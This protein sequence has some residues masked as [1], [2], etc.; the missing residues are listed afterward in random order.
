MNRTHE[1]RHDPWSVGASLKLLIWLC[2][3]PLATASAQTA[4]LPSPD[5]L[6]PTTGVLP[7]GRFHALI[8]QEVPSSGHEL[9][10]TGARWT[11][12]AVEIQISAERDPRIPDLQVVTTKIVPVTVANLPSGSYPVRVGS[13]QV[14]VTVPEQRR[15]RQPMAAR[16]WPADPADLDRLWLL[17]ERPNECA[18][19]RLVEFTA[20]AETGEAYLLVE[21]LPTACPPPG[22]APQL[23]AIAIGHVDPGDYRV[24]LTIQREGDQPDPD[25]SHYDGLIDLHVSDTISPRIGGTWYDPAQS[26]Q[27]I[28]VELIDDGRVLLYWF[29]FDDQGDPAWLIAEGHPNARDIRL[30]AQTVSGGLFPP[31]LDPDLI[32]RRDWGSIDLTFDQCDRGSM[33]WETSAAGFRSGSMPLQRL[34]GRASDGCNAE[35]SVIDLLPPW[36]QGNGSFVRL[37][38]PD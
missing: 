9:R 27:G 20:A 31:N 26:G 3:V 32:D 28:T 15:F 11:G 34:T 33:R 5:F 2:L 4:P 18:D 7:D 19:Y 30:F 29:T 12:S 22:E 1:S 16:W 13:A 24:A 17:F 8:R 14:A 21:E 23:A 36:Y 38:A 6:D 25:R 10:V 35:P 37:S